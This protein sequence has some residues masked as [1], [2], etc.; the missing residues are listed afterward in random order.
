MENETEI[1]KLARMIKSEFD[2]V[3]G[4][5]RDGFADVQGKF[6]DV[7]IRFDAVDK[8]M[9]M[10][11]QKIDHIDAKLDAHRGETKD[12]FATVHRA[13]GGLSATLVDHE[14]RLKAL[15]E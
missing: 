14:E 13:I 15:E 3:R 2:S 12:S 7:N 6:I 4:E 10:L 1:E 11:D 5:M 9:A 8:Q